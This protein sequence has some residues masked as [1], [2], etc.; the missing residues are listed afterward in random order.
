MPKSGQSRADANRKIRK[1]AL[2][3]QLKHKGLCQQVIET[4]E[5]LANLDMP[6]E[7]I[8]VQRLKA[9][10]DGRLAL[11]KKY[12]PDAKA[13]ELTGKDGGDIGIDAGFTITVIDPSAD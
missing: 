13:I 2:I 8:D 6:M 11:V 10:N 9:A 12:L 7:S 5:K 4:C 1:D 3:E